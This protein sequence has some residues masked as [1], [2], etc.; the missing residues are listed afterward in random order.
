MIANWKMNFRLGEAESLSRSIEKGAEK[1]HRTTMVICPP[2][3]FL[4]AVSRELHEVA[5]GAQNFYPREAGNFTGE[6][7]VTQVAEFGEYVIVGHSERRSHFHET[8][9]F[10]QE[11]IDAALRHR[12]VPI[13]CVG[14][15]AHERKAGKTFQ[16]LNAQLRNGLHKI[17]LLEGKH[18]I[19]AYE[20]VWAISGSAE[21]HAATKKE[22]EKAVALIQEFLHSHFGVHVSQTQIIYGGSTTPENCEE[23]FSVPGISGALVGGASHEAPSFLSIA[24]TLSEKQR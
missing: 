2:A 3:I 14:E 16:V 18:L 9:Q 15:N 24:Q 11:K 10:I 5:L 1:I 19:V 23:I 13:L 4:E 20:P 17:H 7:S 21:S 22:I 8:D 6:V 12:L